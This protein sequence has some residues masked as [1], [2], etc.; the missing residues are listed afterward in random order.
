MIGRDAELEVLQDAF[1][2]LFR[3]RQFAAVSVVSASS[4]ARGWLADLGRAAQR[5]ASG[6]MSPLVSAASAPKGSVMASTRSA[7]RVS[8]HFMPHCCSA[9]IMSI[10][11]YG[12]A[13]QGSSHAIYQGFSALGKFVA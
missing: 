8:A 3:E 1:K 13:K 11:T 4:P 2:R 6:D 12:I 9:A 10:C 7:L 5:I